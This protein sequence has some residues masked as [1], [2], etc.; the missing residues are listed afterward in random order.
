M[1]SHCQSIVAKPK[2]C[3]YCKS[4]SSDKLI[5]LTTHI[6]SLTSISCKFHTHK[7]EKQNIL[8]ITK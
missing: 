7:H 3:N 1:M 5:G 2:D 6:C 8:L 4:L